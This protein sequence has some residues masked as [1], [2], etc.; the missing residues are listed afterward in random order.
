MEL[1]SVRDLKRGDTGKDVGDLQTA[2]LNLGY[3]IT[4]TELINQFFGETTHD[5]VV[6]SQKTLQL[7]PNGMLEGKA[8]WLM[9]ANHEHPN[10][11]IVLGQVFDAKGDPQK[12]LIIRVLD[13]DLRSEELIKETKTNNDGE[14]SVFYRDDDFKAAE[15]TRADLFV[16]VLNPTGTTVLAT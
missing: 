9:D 2:L 11:F 15:K 5:A 12:D 13:K 4:D 10:K 7:V 6:C 1:L 8:A 3:R 16:R 14:Y